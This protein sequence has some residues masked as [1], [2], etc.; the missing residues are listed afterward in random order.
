M[1]RADFLLHSLSPEADFN[2]AD[3]EDC[4]L[5]LFLF[6]L[7]RRYR[8]RRNL[9]NPRP[10]RFWVR[11]IFSMSSLGLER[12]VY[13]VCP[14]CT[15]YVLDLSFTLLSISADNV[16]DSSDSSV[17][18]VISV[19]SALSSAL[20]TRLL[21]LFR[22]CMYGSSHSK[23]ENISGVSLFASITDCVPVPLTL[24]LL[25]LFLSLLY[26]FLKFLNAVSASFPK[27]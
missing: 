7:L 20:C 16:E 1:R 21:A 17:L 5:L 9:C 6:V 4:L 23:C 13:F 2:M 18:S 14:L 19:V 26:L 22:G 27:N 15:L 24:T 8:R 3:D 25:I 10:R 11:D 12:F